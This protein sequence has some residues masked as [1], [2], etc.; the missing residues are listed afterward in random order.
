MLLGIKVERASSAA[1]ADLLWIDEV[2]P[3]RSPA[4]LVRRFRSGVASICVEEAE[5]LLADARET[6]DPQR[7]AA[8]LLEAAAMMDKE[9]LFIPIA[10]PIRWSLGSG[11][12]PGFAEIAFARHTLVGLADERLGRQR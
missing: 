4:W 6:L 12:A 2:A 1:S 5:P 3:S 11:R 9:Q 7:R 8:L 10:A